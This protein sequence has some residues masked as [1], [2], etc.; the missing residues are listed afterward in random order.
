[1]RNLAAM[2]PLNGASALPLETPGEE[3]WKT[4]EVFGRLHR[5]K[6]HKV[7]K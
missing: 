7:E 1:M 6:S 5:W 4:N 2:T 3:C